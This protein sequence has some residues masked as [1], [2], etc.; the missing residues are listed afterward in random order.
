MTIAQL[1]CD[2][3]RQ[4]YGRSS[5]AAPESPTSVEAKFEQVKPRQKETETQITEKKQIVER[6]QASIAV[7]PHSALGPWHPSRL[8]PKII[9]QS[10]SMPLQV[11]KGLPPGCLSCLSMHRNPI[12]RV[13]INPVHHMNRVGSICRRLCYSQPTLSTVQKAIR[14]AKGCLLDVTLVIN[15][16]PI[17]C[18]DC[19]RR[20][21]AITGG[22]LLERRRTLVFASMRGSIWGL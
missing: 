4:T 13:A 20:C 14:R 9:S 2:F 12:L 5:G 6:A 16:D 19:L 3:E 11:T 22:L 18:M 15:R 17:N 8:P 10:L 1:Y 21:L 7:E